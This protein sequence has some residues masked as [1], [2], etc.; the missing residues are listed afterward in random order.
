MTAAKAD[1]RNYPG[2]YHDFV[3]KVARKW[4]EDKQSKPLDHKLLYQTLIGVIET[5]LICTEVT[6]SSLESTVLET[7]GLMKAI[8]Q[9]HKAVNECKYAYKSRAT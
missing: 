4:K 9:T 3:Y 2:V 8:N 1:V 7:K 6:V 5:T